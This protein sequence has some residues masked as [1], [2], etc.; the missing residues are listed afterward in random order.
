V[1]E[2]PVFARRAEGS[3]AVAYDRRVL[4]QPGHR[5]FEV[6]DPAALLEDLC[7][8]V[9][10][11]LVTHT[12]EGFRAS[13][14]PMLFDPEDGPFGTLRGHLARGNPQW[15]D[16]EQETLG[17][18][19]FDGPDAYVSPT[20][21]AEKRVTGKVVP[22]WNY[23]TVQAQGLLSVRHEP[24]WLLAHVR[25]L[26]DRH[27]QPRPHPWSLDDTPD[28]YVETQV[29][30]IVGLELRI[31]RLEA[32]RKLS[33]NRSD[34]DIAGTIAGLSSGGPGEQAV[35]ASMLEQKKD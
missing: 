15:R 29:W 13:I 5:K 26:V 24:E 10:G 31:D 2:A 21:Y 34:A 28:G 6:E 7:R 11:T 33:Q 20:W 8:H 3:C 23:I 1:A 17:L 32:K 30:A 22:T 19:I 25:R 14:L 35:A 18:A 4:Y 27:E 12:A 16:V 9:P